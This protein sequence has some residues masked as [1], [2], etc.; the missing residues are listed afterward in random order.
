MPW[1]VVRYDKDDVKRE[2]PFYLGKKFPKSPDVDR[3]GGWHAHPR[4]AAKFKGKLAA[5]TAAIMVSL[6]FPPD[7][8]RLIVKE[9]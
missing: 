9:I 2:L 1:V 4:F 5:E 6:E 7:I 3:K 8:G